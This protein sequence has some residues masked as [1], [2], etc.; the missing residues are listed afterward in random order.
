MP[1][2]KRLKDLEYNVFKKDLD[3]N[4]T[5]DNIIGTKDSGCLTS[6]GAIIVLIVVI[7]CIIGF[8]Q[9]GK[10]G[11]TLT[12]AAPGCSNRLK[13]GSN[14][15]WLHSTQSNTRR[16]TSGSSSSSSSSSS[17]GNGSVIGGSSSSGET[18][19][20]SKIWG[21]AGNDKSNKSSSSSSSSSSGSS[22][23]GGGSSIGN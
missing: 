17:S 11:P 9:V 3:S 16:S 12:C 5:P 10:N 13:P 14:Y 19:T 20:R 18:K 7:V 15:C 1:S 4:N 8:M 6:L 22:S 21:G 2:N 23:S